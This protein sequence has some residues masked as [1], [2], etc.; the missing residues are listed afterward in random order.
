MQDKRKIISKV[1]KFLYKRPETIYAYLH[2]S[3][4]DEILYRDIDIA[5][6]I[7]YKKIVLDNKFD[8]CEQINIEL[9]KLTRIDIDIQILNDAPLGF[10]HSVIKNG[11]LLFSKNDELRLDII[12]KKIQEYIDFYE[13]SLQYL[14]EIA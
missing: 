10:Y 12:E 14:M 3:F 1:K 9:S 7:D 2:G 5:I 11:E 6:Y 4:L 13:Y 8:Y